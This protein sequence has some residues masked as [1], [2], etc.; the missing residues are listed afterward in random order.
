MRRA[1]MLQCTPYGKE[2]PSTPAF[3][4]MGDTMEPI[5]EREHRNGVDDELDDVSSHTSV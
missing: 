3:D 5:D 1:H 4:R 2:C